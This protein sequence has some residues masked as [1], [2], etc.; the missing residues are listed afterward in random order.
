MKNPA[1]VVIERFGGHAVVA[2]ICGVHVSRVY[3]WTY[4]TA[5]G[6]TGGHIPA[7]HQVALMKA[8]QERG[9]DLKPADFFATEAAA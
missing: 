8:A 6:G 4:E 7:K 2:E 3:R 1:D 5:Q 9:V